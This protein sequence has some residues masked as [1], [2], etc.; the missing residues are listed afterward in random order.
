MILPAGAAPRAAMAVALMGVLLLVLSGCGGVRAALGLGKIVPDEFAVVR[1][2]PL[3][4]PP[5]MDLRPPRPGAP[6]SQEVSP[7]EQARSTLLGRSAAAGTG[8]GSAPSSLTPGEKALLRQAG[9]QETPL[10]IREVVRIE[11]AAAGLQDRS[12]TDR[13]LFWRQTKEDEALDPEAEAARQ[14]QEKQTAESPVMESGV[15]IKRKEGG[16]FGKLF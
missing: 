7:R 3:A 14:K 4:M 16:L 6:R 10:N 13:L 15:V 5:D 8:G 9:S 1:H 11:A 2:A 12:F